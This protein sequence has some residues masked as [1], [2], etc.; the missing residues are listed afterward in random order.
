MPGTRRAWSRSLAT[1]EPYSVE[2]RCRRHDGVW[3]WQLGR[4]QAMFD[5]NGTIIAWFGTL[6]DIE[7]G[8]QLRT[9]LAETTRNLRRVIDLANVTL[10]CVDRDL[11]LLFMDG[12]R[13][14]LSVVAGPDEKCKLLL[15]TGLHPCMLAAANVLFPHTQP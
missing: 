1:G 11:K 12:G 7:E 9:Q 4:A 15:P 6:T 14:L 2:Y 10:L 3:R 13:H 5:A 8:M